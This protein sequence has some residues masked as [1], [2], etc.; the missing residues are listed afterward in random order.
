MS[1]EW[2]ES[3]SPSERLLPLDG[4]RGDGSI[5][6]EIGM[7][8]FPAGTYPACSRHGAMNRVGG[9]NNYWR[10]LVHGCNVGAELTP[11]APTQ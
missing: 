9:K 2:R 4:A 10:C 11:E 7:A 3:W 1:G 5:A 6:G 8:R